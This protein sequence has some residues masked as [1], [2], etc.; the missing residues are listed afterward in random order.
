MNKFR[1]KSKS[2]SLLLPV[3][4]ALGCLDEQSGHPVHCIALGVQV[5]SP[6]YSALQI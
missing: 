6:L 5:N 2:N 1:P 3:Q 4:C